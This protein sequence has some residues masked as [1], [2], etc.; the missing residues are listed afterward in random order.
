[1]REPLAIDTETTGRHLDDGARVRIISVCGAKGS[2]VFVLD[3]LTKREVSKLYDK[4]ESR[5]LVLWNAKFD[6][7]MLRDGVDGGRD[8][9]GS[10]EWDG[11]L[12]ARILQPRYE[13]LAL[14]ELAEKLWGPEVN[15]AAQDMKAWLKETKTK[16]QDLV[17]APRNVLHP[18]ARSDAEQTWRMY[19]HQIELLAGVDDEVATAWLIE[20]EFAVMRTLYR[21]EQRGIGWDSTGA[22]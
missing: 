1:M 10:F 11:M 7:H 13:T 3:D 8:L 6:L 16:R 20:R 9:E 18:Y 15:R 14:N 2:R 22:R 21:M 4:F 5:A 12:A 17:K 19:W